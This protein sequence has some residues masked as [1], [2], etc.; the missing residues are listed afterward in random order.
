MILVYGKGSAAQCTSKKV[1]PRQSAYNYGPISEPSE[2]ES[3]AHRAMQAGQ[4]LAASV[5][6]LP[7][8]AL[9]TFSTLP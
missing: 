7:L 1:G 9:E 3:G 4:G 2:V 6:S 8:E 5:P